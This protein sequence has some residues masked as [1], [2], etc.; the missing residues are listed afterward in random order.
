MSILF[1]KKVNLVTFSVDIL[2]SF[3]LIIFRVGIQVLG[4]ATDGD[5]RPLGAM[6]ANM[7]LKL[8]PIGGNNIFFSKDGTVYFQDT[9][10]IGTKLRNRLLKATIL[11][12]FG[13]KP[14]SLTH[15]KELLKLAPKDV[16]G[17]VRSDI[18]PDD[19]QNFRSLQKLM[20]YR[21]EE[22]LK[23]YVIDTE[24]TIVYLQIC[25]NVTSSFLDEKL[26]PDE[27]VYRIWYSVFLLRIWRA[28]LSKSKMYSVK[29]NFISGN[30][31]DCIE[32]NA[33]GLVQLVITLREAGKSDMFLPIL[34][35]S[36]VCE[37]IFRQLRSMGTINWTKINFTLMELLHMVS[38]VELQN[39]IM[40]KLANIVKFP[41]ENLRGTST[42]MQHHQLPSNQE[43]ESIIQR[44]RI[45]AVQCASK[46]GMTCEKSDL[47]ECRLKIREV[48]N[49]QQNTRQDMEEDNFSDSESENSLIY[50]EKI[51]LRDY[52]SELPLVKIANTSKYVRPMERSN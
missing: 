2:K 7:D 24:A 45:E 46:F 8:K 21:V 20:E 6:K 10:H 33:L 12:A 26:T 44:A 34:F 25:R 35:D 39:D 41:R 3:L 22:A 17:L 48:E 15:L 40:Y 38:R 51:N 28:F 4:I 31:F 42:E 9:T 19:R 37:S 1:R 14:I 13:T 36:Q 11:L 43:I 49:I 5:S 23:K 32:L 18:S 30:A 16:H 52:S 29:E 47:H 50:R 27:R